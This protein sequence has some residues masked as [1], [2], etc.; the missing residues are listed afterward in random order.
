MR[1]RLILTLITLA[2]I[3]GCST[4]NVTQD[5]D[6]DVN[7]SGYK[8]Y[9]WLPAADQVEPKAIDLQAK[10]RLLSDRIEKA[11]VRVLQQQGY[12]LATGA[13]ASNDFYVTYHI[14]MTIKQDSRPVQTTVGFSN[15]GYFGGFAFY[16][17]HE[18]YQYQEGQLAIDILD[19]DKKLVWRGV[20]SRAVEGDL[21]PE[22]ITEL[23]NQAVEKILAQF[24]PKP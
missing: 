18:T 19:Q 24:P 14:G 1:S 13:T 16:P 8:T 15:F 9:Q 4:I 21:K 20:S 3:S 2:L 5:Y 7:F 10:N 12:Q 11:M 6:K 23:V 22:K 17:G